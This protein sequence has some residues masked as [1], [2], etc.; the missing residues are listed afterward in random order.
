MIVI[1]F[2][3]YFIISLIN[4][5]KFWSNQGGGV[6]NRGIIVQQWRRVVLLGGEW[7]WRCWR[8]VDA[9][10]SVPYLGGQLALDKLRK[11]SIFIHF[12]SEKSKEIN[13]FQKKEKKGIRRGKSF[14][15]NGWWKRV[16]KEGIIADSWYK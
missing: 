12:S 14:R 8:W 4:G 10:T 9:T 2:T 13:Y 3:S 11:R 5:V 16:K 1:K 15:I 6:D 7:R